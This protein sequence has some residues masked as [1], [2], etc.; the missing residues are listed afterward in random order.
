MFPNI[1]AKVRRGEVLLEK[2]SKNEKIPLIKEIFAN[3]RKKAKT[4]NFS[5]AYGKTAFGFAKDWN[6]SVKEAERFLKLW[7]KER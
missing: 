6:C 5:V 1:Q 7:Y 2:T 4:M 3:E